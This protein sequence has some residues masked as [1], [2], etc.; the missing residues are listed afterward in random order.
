MPDPIARAILDTLRYADVFDYAL[1]RA[2]AHRYLISVAAT[3]EQVE[4]ALED[5]ARL[6]GSVARIGDFLTLPGR[7]SSIAARLHWRDQAEKLWPA[8]RF[9]GRLIAHFPFVRMVAV[10]GGLAMDNARDEDID[11]LIVTAPNRLWLVRGLAV[12]LV[13]LARL[14]GVKLC[15]NFLLTENAL[16]IPTQDLYNAHELA[17]MVPLYGIA[18]HCQMLQVNGWARKFL[19]NAF[20]GIGASENELG[21]A[22]RWIKGFFERVLGGGFGDRVERWEMNRKIRK[23]GAQ[24][25]RNVDTVQFSADVCRGF[26]S[27]HGK[28]ILRE[29]ETR[30]LNDKL[31]LTALE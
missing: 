24:T 19:P 6:N 11:S 27:G 4:C 17:Q 9:Y 20:D 23:L 16:V 2:E 31:Q 1:S 12:A 22:G 5:P 7:E 21:R 10:S 14:R 25:P 13:R 26:F 8:A 15:P 30:S 29:Y 28:R 3:R 18:V